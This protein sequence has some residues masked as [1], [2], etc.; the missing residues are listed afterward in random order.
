M[1]T[2]YTVALASCYFIRVLLMIN[3]N[4]FCSRLGVVMHFGFLPTSLSSQK[5]VITLN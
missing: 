5:N 1:R 3:L 2:N 4:A